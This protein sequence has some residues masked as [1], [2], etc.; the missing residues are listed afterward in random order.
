M[1]G[2]DPN[3]DSITYEEAV[4]VGD[5]VWSVRVTVQNGTPVAIAATVSLGA[6]PKAN[7][8]DQ[9]SL[10]TVARRAMKAAGKTATADK[11]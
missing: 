10:A 4:E 9:L 6:D 2:Y 8:L 5:H 3:Q 7:D 11:E 1:A